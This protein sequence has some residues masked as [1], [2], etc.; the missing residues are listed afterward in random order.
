MHDSQSCTRTH[1]PILRFFPS[2]VGQGALLRWSHSQYAA[3]AAQRAAAGGVTA[4]A[5]YGALA[6]YFSG[7]Y[8]QG[9]PIALKKRGKRWGS[10]VDAQV[11][12][13]RGVRVARAPP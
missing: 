7:R 2:A 6:D 13:R 11:G 3:V 4:A 12:G 9:K 5:A 10:L 8:A 1:S